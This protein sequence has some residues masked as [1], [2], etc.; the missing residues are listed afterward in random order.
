MK[1]IDD[2]DCVCENHL[3]SDHA[4]PDITSKLSCTNGDALQAAIKAKNSRND[5]VFVNVQ[6]SGSS[7]ERISHHDFKNFQDA[8]HINLSDN[9]ISVIEKDAFKN[10]KKLEVLDLSSNLLSHLQENAFKHLIHLKNLSI[11]NNK[12]QA[13]ENNTFYDLHNLLHLDLSQ[14]NLSSVGNWFASLKNLQFLSL[15]HNEITS[16]ANNSFNNLIHLQSLDLSFNF[17]QVIPN[18]LFYRVK[19]LN[20]LS[21]SM[22]QLKTLNE[23]TFKGN[24][25]LERINLT[26]NLWICDK[27]LLPLHDWLKKYET[28]K[29]LAVCA[30][31]PDMRYYTIQHALEILFLE[32]KV[33]ESPTCNA[34]M[35]NCTISKDKLVVTVDCSNRGFQ[36]LPEMVPYKTKALNLYNNKIK[37]LNIDHI[38]ATLW[39]DVSFLY[40]N[41]NIIDSVKGLEGNWLLKNLVALHLSYNRLTEIPIH[42]L[43]QIRGGL[44]DELYLSG[45][46]WTCDCNT[47]RFQAWLQDNYRTVRNFD[48][49]CCSADSGTYSNSPIYRLKKSQLCPQQ[50]HSVNILDVVNILM[51]LVI[52]I[53]I[54]KLSYDY[55]LQKRTG[56]LPRFFSLNN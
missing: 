3:L 30:E 10:F 41:N 2:S 18:F 50:E 20:F 22:N 34:T 12:L 43:E 48:G 27:K 25:M 36:R 32:M 55:W 33:Q 29:E 16:I 52:V 53:I 39:S 11:S 15:S 17:L 5:L 19:N 54:C 45:N 13:I 7:L 56:K 37:S 14:N 49:I 1:K 4:D 42:I 38:N 21:L 31:P 47:V 8:E 35:C 26:G 51:A 9:K 24:T 23:S 44:L 46:P 28:Y 6:I 40:L